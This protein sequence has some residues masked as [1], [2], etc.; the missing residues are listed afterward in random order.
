MTLLTEIT[1]IHD[2]KR[3]KNLSSRTSDSVW[4]KSISAKIIELTTVSFGFVVS[5]FA[6]FTNIFEKR[7]KIYQTKVC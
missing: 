4:V 5:I 7:G 6:L 2:K 1:Y 3:S